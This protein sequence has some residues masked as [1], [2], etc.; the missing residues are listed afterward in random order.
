MT[1]RKEE[2]R[3]GSKEGWKEGWR[4]E[5]LGIT[6]QAPED[7]E[8]ALLRYRRCGS[9]VLGREGKEGRDEEGRMYRETDR[10][11]A[12]KRGRK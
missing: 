10:V 11:Y 12:R 6:C 4:E 3:G 2:T 8:R 7:L 9:G 1:C 5:G